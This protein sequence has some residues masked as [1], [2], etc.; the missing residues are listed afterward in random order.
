MDREV[1]SIIFTI[2]IVIVAFLIAWYHEAKTHGLVDGFKNIFSVEEIKP[3]RKA[4]KHEQT[5][6]AA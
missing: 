4:A 2:G 6:K 1:S 3:I 5:K